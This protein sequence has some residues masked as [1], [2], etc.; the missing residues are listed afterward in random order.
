MLTMTFR[1]PNLPALCLGL[2][3]ALPAIAATP[4]ADDPLAAARSEFA[5][6]LAAAE[7]GVP[8][9]A[10]D[11][12]RL[13]GYPLFP[14]LEAARLRLR[15]ARRAA[16]SDGDAGL[17]DAIAAFL[18][19]QGAAPVA[20]E[21]RSQWAAHLV[22]REDWARYLAA[23]GASDDTAQRCPQFAARIA[24]GQT[25]GLA[26]PV[27]AQWQAAD[28]SLPACDAAFDWARQTGLLTPALIE[29]RARLVVRS[30]YGALGK[31]I[32]TPL[33]EASRARI[34]QWAALIEQPQR[35]IDVLIADP[36]RPVD[37]EALLDGWQRL[38]RK[39]PDAAL[40]RVAALRD[41]R[42]L[43]DAAAFSPYA[44]ALALGLAWSRRPEAR[45]WFARIAPADVDALAAEWWARA[46]L[47]AGDW[48]TV[49][50][51]IA[52]MPEAARAEQRWRYWSARAA[53]ASGAATAKAQLAALATE[54]GW[55]PALAAAQA[56]QKYAPH[57]QPVAR[58]DAALARLDADAGLLRAREL[59]RIGQRTPASVEFWAA[60]AALDA[61]LK[62]QAAVLAM[63]WGWHE[64]GVAAASSQK[65]FTDYALLYP[66]P[67]DAPVKA[68]SALSGLPANLIY[69]LLRQES[70][71][72]A[73]AVS[74]ANAYGLTQMLI[75]TAERTAR[76]W[77]QPKPTRAALFDPATSVPL[78]AAHLRDLVDRFKGQ[79]PVAIAGYNAGPNAAARWLPAQPLP[80]DIWIENIPFNETR[81]YVQRVLWHALVFG[82]LAD[83]GKPQ[84][85]EPWL[86]PVVH[87]DALT[88]TADGSAADSPAGTP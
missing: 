3:L 78:G 28:K 16:S 58:D 30:G 2:A 21:L 34:A 36:A 41:A 67:Y 47:W 70:L 45:D 33:P 69:G 74:R 76:K 31:L 73:D 46:A 51:A 53:A 4:L 61:P 19:K 56:G 9:V 35:E 17:D 77:Q 37:G 54:D 63:R 42:Q 24:L 22:G 15:M 25:D 83:G 39:D 43:G 87:P 40:A 75:E 79:Q 1:F 57:P 50:R 60:L 12:E 18:A 8:A 55:Y 27:V 7:A 72:R 59:F 49:A 52:A 48:P 80:A 81:T 68:G 29:A 84:P 13:R 32:A 38:A 88:A 86:A 10:D 85:V 62:S 23:F 26:A 6:A 44:R 20:K 71:Y 65:I 14:Y 66:R 82:W 11:G 5:L 64:Q